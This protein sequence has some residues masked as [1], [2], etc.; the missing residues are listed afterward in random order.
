MGQDLTKSSKVY[1]ELTMSS[2]STPGVTNSTQPSTRFSE[3]EQKS[4]VQA[5]HKLASLSPKDDCIDRRTFEHY[6]PLGGILGGRLFTS[7]DKNQNGVIDL[8]EFL[9]GMSMCLEGSNDDKSQIAFDMFNLDGSDGVSAGEMY[10]AIKSVLSATTRTVNGKCEDNQPGDVTIDEARVD[11]VARRIVHDAFTNQTTSVDKDNKLSVQV[12]KSWMECHPFLLDSIFGQSC[13]K[14]KTAQFTRL[15]EEKRAPDEGKRRVYGS[16]E[17]RKQTWI[18]LDD[19][20]PPETDNEPLFDSSYASAQ[21][22]WSPVFPQSKQ[23]PR[24]RSKLAACLLHDS[25]Y[26]YGGRGACSSLKDLWRYDIGDNAWMSVP[27]S[28]DNRPPSLQEHTM[29]AFKEK[30]IIFG[31]EF[32]SS[33]ETPLWMFDTTSLSWSR[34]FQRGPV[35]RKSHSAVV[36]GDC[37]FIFGGYIDIRGATNELWKYDIGTDKWSRE[38]SRSSQWPSP[39]YSH[40]AAVFDKSMV[41]FGGLEE[42]QCKNDLWLWNIAA[43]KWT[44][45]KAKGS[46]PPIFGHT[47]AKVG[48]G[49]LVFGGESTDGTLYNHLWRFDFDLRSWTAISTRGLIYPPARS[50]HSIIT[51]PDFLISS[52]RPTSAHSAPPCTPA[53][54]REDSLS[55]EAVRTDSTFL[56]TANRLSLATTVE[57]VKRLRVRPESAMTLVSDRARESSGSL[58]SLSSAAKVLDTEN[59]RNHVTSGSLDSLISELDPGHVETLSM[60]NHGVDMSP[61]SSVTQNPLGQNTCT[62]ANDNQGRGEVPDAHHVTSFTGTSKAKTIAPNVINKHCVQLLQDVATT[63]AGDRRNIQQPPQALLKPVSAQDLSPGQGPARVFPPVV[64]NSG[65]VYL[66]V[67]GGLSKRVDSYGKSIDMWRCQIDPEITALLSVV[68]VKRSPKSVRKILVQGTTK[69]SPTTVSGEYSRLEVACD[70]FESDDEAPSE[71]VLM[72]VSD[73][74]SLDVPLVSRQRTSNTSSKT[75]T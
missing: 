26:M 39:R 7:F 31:G 8:N 11:R 42:L 2:I 14:D 52:F 25:L 46:P 27:S 60:V 73:S 24:S 13:L 40:S 69:S 49:M 43:K 35:N 50:H 29:T 45:I 58:G 74:D 61:S 55:L 72:D 51:I 67:L 64:K 1:D 65:I 5:F 59:R 19:M 54:D 15:E 32:T 57:I 38:R 23:K 71:C 36:C 68:P 28:G 22:L 30:L 21:Y 66:M 62:A 17:V 41:V 34:S 18:H 33:T 75:D 20:K 6:F 48:D 9:E 37:L 16:T 53:L 4:L 56:A 10:I 3:C 70:A 44:R 63:S 12:F 47:A